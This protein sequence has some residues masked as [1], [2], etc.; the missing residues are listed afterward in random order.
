MMSKFATSNKLLALQD[1]YNMIATLLGGTRAMRAAGETYL[2]REP[3]EDRQNYLSRLNR[4]VLHPIYER[5]ISTSVSKIFG[6]ALDIQVSEQLNK[7]IEDC[8]GSGTSFRAF[9]RTAATSACHYGVAYILVDY[10]NLNDATPEQQLAAYPYLTLIPANTALNVDYQY[11]NGT[12]ELTNF[13]YAENHPQY[14]DCVREFVLDPQTRQVS[15]QLWAQVDGKETAVEAGEIMGLDLIPIVAVYTNKTEPFMGKPLLSNLAEMNV[16]HWQMTSDY[17]NITHTVQCPM[18]VVTG[19][20]P[21]IEA[22]GT[23]KEIVI[24]PNTVFTSPAA[25][26]SVSWVE[27]SGNSVEVGRTAIKDLESQMSALGL[28]IVSPQSTQETATGRLLDAAET[29]SVLTAIAM[30]LEYALANT[31]WYAASYL[32]L[33]LDNI[34]VNINTDYTVQQTQNFP[35]VMELFRSGVITAQTLLDWVAKQ[36]LL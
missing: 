6:Q 34:Q 27:V 15:Y 20:T 1:D 23:T 22:D 5:T 24:S 8:D 14:G 21:T 31:L 13:R 26:A 30:D 29:H 25:D 3:R 10:P 32:R 33:P 18:L 4:T 11:I 16:T 7:L 17:L 36:N 12:A 2:P 35:Q 28:E 9:A 19:Y